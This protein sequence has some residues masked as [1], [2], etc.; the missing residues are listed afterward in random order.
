MSR[1]TQSLKAAD[2]MY[3]IPYTPC[4]SLT[5]FSVPS[6]QSLHTRNGFES[7]NPQEW[8][9]RRQRWVPKPLP[10]RR[11]WAVWTREFWFPKPFDLYEVAEYVP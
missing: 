2:W 1:I 9:D 8:Y 7:W 4:Q 10:K 6:Y 11:W 3:M 5:S